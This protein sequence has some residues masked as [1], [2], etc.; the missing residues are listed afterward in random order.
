MFMKHL[1]WPKIKHEVATYYRTCHACQV[2]GKP[3]QQFPVAPL[4]P[5]PL[6]NIHLVES[7]IMWGHSQKICLETSI[8]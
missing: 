2:V 3:N 5:I 6:S 8:S 4:K 1:Y 7:L